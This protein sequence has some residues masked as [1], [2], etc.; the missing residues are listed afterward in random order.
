M[1]SL[2]NPPPPFKAVGFLTG[3]G[4]LLSPISNTV[5]LHLHLFISLPP[6]LCCGSGFVS[7]WFSSVNLLLPTY[8]YLCPNHLSTLHWFTFL[9]SLTWIYEFL[10]LLLS[11][12]TSVP[13]FS[14]NSLAVRS[15]FLLSASSLSFCPLLCISSYPKYWMSEEW[16]QLQYQASVPSL[17]RS[18]ALSLSRLI[19]NTQRNLRSFLLI[20]LSIQRFY[21]REGVR[22]YSRCCVFVLMCVPIKWCIVSKMQRL[23]HLS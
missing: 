20:V 11:L 7:L 4:P 21:V 22:S 23:V 10:F 15:S 3:R 6:H 18:L 13:Y 8:N 9:E 1:F 17:A 19:T 14:L 12:C 16:E 2:F 5:D